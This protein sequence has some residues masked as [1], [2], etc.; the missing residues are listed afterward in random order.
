MSE[1]VVEG[2]ARWCVAKVLKRNVEYLP[3]R[4][5]TFRALSIQFMGL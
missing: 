4:A 1:V 3:N 2:K 5:P